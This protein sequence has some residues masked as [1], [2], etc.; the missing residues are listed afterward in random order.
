MRAAGCMDLAF[1]S[2]QVVNLLKGRLLVRISVF[3]ALHV[4][5]R[6][7]EL[8]PRRSGENKEEEPERRHRGD[9]MVSKS[10]CVESYKKCDFV[11]K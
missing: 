9:Q 3:V 11:R 4:L 5:V 2:L 1:L 8:H 7:D 6:G 10:L